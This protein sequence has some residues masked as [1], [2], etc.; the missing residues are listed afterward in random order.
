VTGPTA[1]RAIAPSTRRR[2]GEHELVLELRRR[3]ATNSDPVPAIP[4]MT[5]RSRFTRE[6][7]RKGRDWL[8][9]KAPGAKRAASESVGASHPTGACHPRDRRA[10]SGRTIAPPSGVMRKG[11]RLGLDARGGGAGV[12]AGRVAPISHPIG[13]HHSGERPPERRSP[14]RGGHHQMRGD[15]PRRG[16]YPSEVTIGGMSG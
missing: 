2:P 11:R 6:G 3:L 8:S 14:F 10:S 5:C 16:D 13:G 15:H 12:R 4:R 1:R 7:L 9:P